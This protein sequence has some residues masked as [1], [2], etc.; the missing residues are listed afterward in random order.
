MNSAAPTPAPPDPRPRTQAIDYRKCFQ[1]LA[2]L[3][4]TLGE[5]E[6]RVLVELTHRT[7]TSPTHTAAIGARQ[8]AKAA[9]TAHSNVRLAVAALAARSLI[10]VRPGLANRPSIFQVNI[11]LTADFASSTGVPATGT[12]LCSQQAHPC[13]YSR[14]TPVPA[15]GTPP[16]E[17]Q[18]LALLETSVDIHRSIPEGSIDT[19]DPIER[20]I[21]TKPS[22]HTAADLEA[23]RALMYGY[24]RKFPPLEEV[25]REPHPP[26][27]D[28]CA[29]FLAVAPLPQLE[30]LISDLFCER[31]TCGYSYAWFVSVALQRIH[32]ISPKVAKHR[33]TQLAAVPT[34]T[35]A[36]VA[37]GDAGGDFPQLLQELARTKAL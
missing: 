16:T 21:R 1:H 10:T 18:Q 6:L 9:G 26:D 32:G 13:A 35:R 25:G 15:T 17:N 19:S 20:T 5:A 8:L 11:W 37:A 28:I 7:A 34:K 36:A 30:R 31:R 29:R 3:A 4:P 14:H 12:P 2:H 23:A 27:R 22:E 24:R 33:K